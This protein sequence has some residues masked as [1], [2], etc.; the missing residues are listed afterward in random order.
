[1]GSKNRIAKY[2]I[3]II[4]DRYQWYHQY[5]EPFVGGGGLIDKLK[6]FD[7]EKIGYDINP[8][9]IKALRLIRDNPDSLP[10]NKTEFSED[11]YNALKQNKNSKKNMGMIGF[12]AF[13]YSYGG[14]FWGGFS[15]DKEGKRDYIE[16]AY[17]NA[18]AQS[19]N[20]QGI[21]FKCKSFD[22][23]EINEKSIIYCD[24]PYQGAT[25]YKDSF[26]HERFW[27]WC[28]EKAKGGHSVF[29]SEYNSPNDFECL[30]EKEIVSSLTKNTGEKKATE[31]LFRPK[32]EIYV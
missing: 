14:K 1:M 24:P 6:D 8:Y 3:P 5:I 29:V 15:R 31:K 9:T 23:I 10:K 25:K 32:K 16:E 18:I 22:K 27:D 13:S 7:I 26:D 20:I 28:R 4:F 12:C 30:W 2:I 17:K 11:D 19:K 21:K